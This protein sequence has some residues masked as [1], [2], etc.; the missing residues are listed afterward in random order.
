MRDCHCLD[1]VT[2]VKCVAQRRAE[3]LV[4]ELA[5]ALETRDPLARVHVLVEYDKWREGR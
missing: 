1:C 5:A 2:H 4:H 3:Q